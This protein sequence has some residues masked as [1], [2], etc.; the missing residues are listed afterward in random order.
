MNDSKYLL[1]AD[2]NSNNSKNDSI[3]SKLDS[4]SLFSF[5][6][7]VPEQA[8][9]STSKIFTKGAYS[10]LDSSLSPFLGVLGEF[11]ISTSQNN[12]LSQWSVAIVGGLYF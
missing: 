2:Y 8:S 4:Q 9:A 3:F 6:G 11:E 12:A 1:V 10:W 5:E 7:D